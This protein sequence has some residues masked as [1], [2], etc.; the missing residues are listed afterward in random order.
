MTRAEQT[1]LVV[2]DN[3]AGRY[4]KS[5]ILRQARHTDAGRCHEGSHTRQVIDVKL[6]A[7]AQRRFKAFGTVH[8]AP[9]H[10][11]RGARLRAR[12]LDLMRQRPAP[13]FEPEIRVTR[14][15]EA[16]AVGRSVR[17]RLEDGRRGCA[18]A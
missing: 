2:D 8:Q 9:G 18:Q 1:V 11:A 12:R 15:C 17:R 13:L 6:G 5:R 3:D 10:G 7:A 16:L 4:R 14:E